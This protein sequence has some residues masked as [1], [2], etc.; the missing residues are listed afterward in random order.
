MYRQQGA[1]LERHDVTIY[2]GVRGGA[3][4][5]RYDVQA[6]L[7]VGRRLNYLF[8]S[9]YSLGNPVDAVDIQNVSF[10]MIISPR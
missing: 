8:Q 1:R 3:R 6:E 2:S 10:G 5:S 7:S 9:D 4:L